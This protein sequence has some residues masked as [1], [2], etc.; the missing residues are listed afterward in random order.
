VNYQIYQPTTMTEL[1]QGQAYAFARFQQGENLFISGPGGS[2]KSHLVKYFVNELHTLGKIHQV[3]STTGCS[4]ILLSNNIRIGGRPIIVKTIHSWSGIRLAKGSKEDIIKLVQK[5]KRVVK[6]W[7]RIKTLIIDEVS[8]MSYKIFDVLE[9]LARTLRK[10]DRPFGG[11]QII[12]LGDFF[13]L[14]PV[15]DYSD[16]ASSAFCFEAPAWNRVFSLE[17]HIEL[18]TIFRQTNPVYQRILNEVR[19]GQLSEESKEILSQRVGL[20]Y[21]SENHGGVIP[22]KIFATR[23]QVNMINTTQYEKLEEKEQVYRSHTSTTV[24]QYIDSGELLDEDTLE[25]CRQLSMMEVEYECNNLTNNMPSDPEVKLKKG[26]P[27]MCLVNLDVESGIA[28]GS[29]GV[30]EDFVASEDSMGGNIPL[31]RFANG[32]LKPIAKYTWQSSEFPTICVSQ[33]PL[34]LAYANSIHKMQGS[35]LD[36]CEM[37]LGGSIFAEHQI[38]VALSRVKSIDGVYLTAFHPHR[39]RVN[40]HVVQFYRQFRSI[41]ELSEVAATKV[42][43]PVEPNVALPDSVETECPICLDDMEKPHITECS[44]VF[45]Q[46][47]ITRLISCTHTGRASCPMCRMVVTSRSLKSVL[48]KT[49]A[50]NIPRVNPRNI[51]RDPTVQ[52][53]SGSS[54]NT[55]AYQRKSV[56]IPPPVA[57]IFVKKTG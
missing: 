21:D 14:P 15:G 49:K 47:C 35:T 30:I 36:V 17:N 22:M 7:K 57:S 25:R 28:N 37:N 54:L 10:N 46:D 39:I 11:I 2:G 29:M 18:T 43:D 31:V 45:C 24:K 20:T 27:V 42:D 23:N 5:N 4:S 48:P 19:I 52:S 44:H 56:V 12:C 51:M 41:E 3:T 55:R 8:M 33:I 16:P 50:K 13:Q 6:E 9:T 53:T 32:V 34:C 1:S 26:T 40:P 38:Y